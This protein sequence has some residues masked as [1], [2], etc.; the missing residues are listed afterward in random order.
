MVIILIVLG[1]ETFMLTSLFNYFWG[2]SMVTSTLG[3]LIFV[4]YFKTFPKLLRQFGILSIALFLL[5]IYSSHNYFGQSLYSG[6]I[7]SSSLYITGSAFLIYYLIIK[8]KIEFNSVTK[9]ITKTSWLV[10]FAL[11]LVYLIGTN[12]GLVTESSERAL[13]KGFINFGAIIYLAFFFKRKHFA[14]LFF[15]LLLFSTNH[16]YDFQRIIVFAYIACFLILTL[17]FRRK[18]VSTL[19]LMVSMILAPIIFTIGANTEVGKMVEKKISYIFQIFEDDKDKRNNDDSSITV[20]YY[21]SEY[22][23]E[24]IKKHPITGV[25]IIRS[26]EKDKYIKLDHFYVSDIGLIGV[27]YSFGIIGAFLYFFQWRYFFKR[28]INKVNELSD[29]E[30]GLLI[31]ILYMLLRTISTGSTLNA[32]AEF[33]IIVALFE[34]SRTQKLI[35]EN[36]E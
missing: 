23:I 32:P 28:F 35:S 31:Y 22:A 18:N 13:R 6:V 20:R 14:Y 1:Y 29:I 16:W 30:L 11:I 3:F 5:S 9:S 26:S 7:A 10:F 15:S 2:I 34:A 12:I 17:Y 24:S 25:G 4:F 19:V 8:Y 36:A 21:E 27:Y 33:L